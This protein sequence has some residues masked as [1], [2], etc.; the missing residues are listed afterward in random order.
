MGMFDV[1]SF[2]I[3]DFEAVG[4]VVRLINYFCLEDAGLF[5]GSR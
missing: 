4:A 2:D 1:T 5:R 3:D